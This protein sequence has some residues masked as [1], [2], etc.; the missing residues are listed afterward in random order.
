MIITFIQNL[1]PNHTFLM[2]GNIGSDRKETH[3]GRMYAATK[4]LTQNPRVIML[5]VYRNSKPSLRTFPESA[6]IIVINVFHNTTFNHLS[7]ER[8]LWESQHFT[9]NSSPH[10]S[11]LRRNSRCKSRLKL[12]W[13]RSVYYVYKCIAR[14]KKEML[15]FVINSRNERYREKIFDSTS[16]EY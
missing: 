1:R 6:K 9:C 12:N 5:I 11:T 7:R 16:C 13:W 4:P 3:I 8:Y 10:S 2:H 14:Q 15:W